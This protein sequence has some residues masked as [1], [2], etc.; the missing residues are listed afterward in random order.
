MDPIYSIPPKAKFI[1]P[2]KNNPVAINFLGF[3]LSDKDP[4]RN[5]LNR[6]QLK[7]GYVPDHIMIIG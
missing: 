2:V 7:K 6:M 4:I 1:T 5:F 3:A